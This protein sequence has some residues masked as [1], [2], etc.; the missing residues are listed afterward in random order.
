MFIVK[1]VQ[2]EKA[3]GFFALGVL[4][5][6]GADALRQTEE[7]GLQAEAEAE[8]DSLVLGPFPLPVGPQLF[9]GLLSA[10]FNYKGRSKTDRFLASEPQSEGERIL[11][12]C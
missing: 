6:V 4:E 3:E 8:L 2:V 1:V 12:N 7:P 10:I 9:I 11:V 5:V